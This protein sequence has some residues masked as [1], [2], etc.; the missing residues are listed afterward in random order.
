MRNNDQRA[1]AL[2]P[3]QQ[4]LDE[5]LRGRVA[6]VRV[7]QQEQDGGAVQRCNQER[8]EDFERCVLALRG[9]HLGL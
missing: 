7:L 8:F 5:R 6:P 9:C 2:D 3:A 4:A 1:I